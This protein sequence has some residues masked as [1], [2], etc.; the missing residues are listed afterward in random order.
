MQNKI[1][2]FQ[3]L[4]GW[5][6]FLVFLS[7]CSQLYNINGVNRLVY[8]GC[9]GVSIFIILSGFLTAKNILNRE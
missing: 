3:G 6:I 2:A 8:F 4:R 5:A 1:A 7:H 9:A